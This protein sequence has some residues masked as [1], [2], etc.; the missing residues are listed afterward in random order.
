MVFIKDVSGCICRF[1]IYSFFV[2]VFCIS[3]FFQSVSTW[4]ATFSRN[5]VNASDILIFLD[6]H[7]LRFSRKISQFDEK[8]SH[9]SCC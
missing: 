5:T 3:L 4:F 8:S 9:I 7:S 1:S 2:S 6:C